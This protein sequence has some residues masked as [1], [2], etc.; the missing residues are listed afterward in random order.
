MLVSPCT[1]IPP[2]F[3]PPLAGCAA[4]VKFLLLHL[5]LH[6]LRQK[7]MQIRVYSFRVPVSSGHKFI[8][9]YIDTYRS[10]GS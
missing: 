9:R 2:G 10:D 5:S 6:G 3:L 7:T 1:L 4:G 8:V